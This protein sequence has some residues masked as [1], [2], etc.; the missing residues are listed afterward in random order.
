MEIC[1]LEKTRAMSGS[2]VDNRLKTCKIILRGCESPVNKPGCYHQ[3]RVFV[4]NR[5]RNS[6]AFHIFFTSK[7]VN[8]K[9]VVGKMV[10]INIS[11]PLINTHL[12]I[13]S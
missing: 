13:L 4:G 3:S 9:Q 6:D 2:F 12:L 8:Q 7:M 5:Y 1:S 10:L 11:T